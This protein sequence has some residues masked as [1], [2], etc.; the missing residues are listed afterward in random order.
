MSGAGGSAGGAVGPMGPRGPQGV[1]GN[2]GPKG[3]PGEKGEQGD[4]GPQGEQGETPVITVAEDSPLSYKV[5]FQTGN[6]ELVTPNL[7]APAEEYHVNL[8]VVNSIL[9]VPVKNLELTYQTTSTTALR[10]SI[11]PIKTDTPVLADI[12]RTSV[13]N[14]GTVEAQTFN[15]ATVSGRTVLDDIV[16]TQSQETHSISIR[17]QDPVTK[18]WSLCEVRSFLSAGAARTS[19]RV[20]WIE[21]NVTYEVPTV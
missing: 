2:T 19:V 17:Q 4:P 5:R 1:R 15:N 11:A 16:Y 12:R 6:Q 10:I 8:S 9:T 18:L 3:D 21:D 20:Q 14:G 13:Y 7:F